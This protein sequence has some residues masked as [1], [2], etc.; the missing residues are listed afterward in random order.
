[1][2]MIM[3]MMMKKKKKKKK[4]RLQVYH[5]LGNNAL[6]SKRSCKYFTE[7]MQSDD[8]SHNAHYKHRHAMLSQTCIN[9]VLTGV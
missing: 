6:T 5:V 2:M 8:L 9:N 7:T 1:M 4:R 3:M